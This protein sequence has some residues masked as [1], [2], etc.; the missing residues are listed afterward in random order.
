MKQYIYI[1][2]LI[3]LTVRKV[4]YSQTEITAPLFRNRL[5]LHLPLHSPHPLRSEA[6]EEASDMTL[7]FGLCNSVLIFHGTT[8]TASLIAFLFPA[9]SASTS[10]SVVAAVLQ[11]VSDMRL[12]SGGER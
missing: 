8:V 7:D 4:F 12:E 3:E 9:F 5:V 6:Y 10:L 1:V 2:V 11:E